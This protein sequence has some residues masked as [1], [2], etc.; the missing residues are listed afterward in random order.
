MKPRVFVDVALTRFPQERLSRLTKCGHHILGIVAEY[1]MCATSIYIEFRFERD[2]MFVKRPN[3]KELTA[4]LL[5]VTQGIAGLLLSPSARTSVPQF[6][7]LSEQVPH[8][9][10]VPLGMDFLRADDVCL[11]LYGYLEAG[12][13][14]DNLRSRKTANGAEFRRGTQAVH[15][16]PE[17][18]TVKVVA[19]LGRCSRRERA[20]E[21]GNV[22]SSRVRLDDDFMRSVTF[23]ASW[24]HSFDEKPAELGALA[25]GRLPNPTQLPNDR[26][27]WE[28]EFEVRSAGVSLSDALVIILQ[29]R[30]EKMIARMSARLPNGL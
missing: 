6:R 14:F 27:W 23:E 2:K 12:D 1:A 10:T 15:T 28:Y 7:P 30:D 13:F 19:Q 16:F 11:I 22:G 17:S 3:G 20:L 9:K 29:S 24:N 21:G 26:D 8:G 4:R 25:A 18:V 5:R